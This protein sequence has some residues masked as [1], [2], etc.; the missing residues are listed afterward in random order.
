MDSSDGAG[1]RATYS[2]R[3]VSRHQ[4]RRPALSGLTVNDR[5]GPPV[6]ARSGH[7][8]TPCR[9]A[10]LPL[11]SRSPGRAGRHQGGRAARWGKGG[12]CAIAERRRRRP[13]GHRG[14][15][16]HPRPRGAGNRTLPLAL[17][18]RFSR[19][20]A[21][22]ARRRRLDLH[23][24]GLGTSHASK[25]CVTTTALSRR[26]PTRRWRGHFP[27]SCVGASTCDC[28]RNYNHPRTSPAG[29]SAALR[30]R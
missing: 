4:H 14:D 26:R 25:I 18:P 23:T 27:T 21:P 2:I 28:N 22:C 3:Q 9:S 8:R 7:E 24:G 30:D 19:S 11:D 17:A 6:R 29:Y 10:N 1:A 5:S 16:D 13:C 12:S 15:V 20:S